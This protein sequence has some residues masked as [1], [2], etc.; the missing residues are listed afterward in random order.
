MKLKRVIVFLLCIVT[1]ATGLSACGGGPSKDVL[2]ILSYKPEYA[3]FF[4]EVNKVF[5]EE[6][7][8]IKSVDLKSVDTNDYNTVLQS[9]LQ[10]KYLDVFTSEVTY[11]MQGHNN[12]MLDLG[13]EEYMDTINEK[14]ITAGS[15]FDPD[16]DTESKLLT[17]PLEEAANVVFYNKTIFDEYNLT[18]P[19]TWSEFIDL[20]D[21]FAEYAQYPAP[22][23][24][25]IASPIVFGGKSEWPSM[26][27]LNAIAADVVETGYP[28]FYEEIKNYDEY[29]SA[30]FT[31]AVWIETFDKMQT[32]AEYID[33]TLYG[34]DYSFASTYF[35][36]GKKE[37]GVDKYYPMMIDGTWAYSQ[38]TGDFEVGI[39]ALPA[40]DEVQTQKNVAY[41]CGTTLSVYKESNKPELA[42]K[43]LEI[44]FR[45]EVYEKFLELT[46]MPSVK[47]DA[48]QSDSLI[49]TFFSNEEYRF[50]EAYDSR[51][52][53]YFPLV[54]ASTAISLMRGR[55]TPS[56]VASELQEQIE[57]SKPDWQKWTQLRHVK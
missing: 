53:R 33:K 52:P 54:S 10:S 23:K 18:V 24:T 45:K 15:F 43:Y 50:V 28:T 4:N 31:D 37:H 21:L 13:R 29:P 42:K 38:I 49:S 57:L 22:G 5:L 41:K 25:K 51:M 26:V 16:K 35:S 55:L 34:I 9:R 12:Y 47:T 36:I 2:Y 19:Q 32:V 7:P 39:F 3:E 6:N 17:L 56:T 1:F 11:M 27:I 30:R 40:L 46:K 8:E 14:Y 44:C 20:C 48:V